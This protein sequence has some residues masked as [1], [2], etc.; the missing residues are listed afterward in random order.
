MKTLD[1]RYKK[2]FEFHNLVRNF[3]QFIEVSKYSPSELREALMYAQIRVETRIVR[4]MALSADLINELKIR[5]L[6]K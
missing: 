2:D 1:E 4:P 3:E 5:S 6:L